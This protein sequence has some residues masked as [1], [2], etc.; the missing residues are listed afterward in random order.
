[1][2]DR[3]VC[4]PQ[5]L[6]AGTLTGP[7][8]SWSTRVAVIAGPFTVARASL[9]RVCVDGDLRFVPALTGTARRHGACRPS[10]PRRNTSEWRHHEGVVDRPRRDGLGKM[11]TPET[12]PCG[13][14]AAR[15]VRI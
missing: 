11:P 6:S 13:T 7:R 14:T 1:S 9:S 12:P 8:L 4:A 5:S 3:C 2:R 15:L 10:Q